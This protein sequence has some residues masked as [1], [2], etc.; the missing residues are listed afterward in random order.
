MAQR[1]GP[2]KTT[3]TTRGF[4][5]DSKLTLRSFLSPKNLDLSKAREFLPF[6]VPVTTTSVGR[7]SGYIAMSHVAS[8][9]LGTI[10]MAGHQI[11]LSIF[12]C[13]TPFVDALSQVA[14]SLV[15]EVFAA[16]GEGKRR[17]GRR[18]RAIA[19][20]RTIHNFRKVGVG[21][22]A[23]LVGL[24]SVIPLISRYFTT[25]ASV[26]ASVHGAIKPL[27]MFMLV[28]GLMCAGEGEKVGGGTRFLLLIVRMRLRVES[29]NVTLLSVSPPIAPLPTYSNTAP[30]STYCL[31]DL[32][33]AHCWDRRI[34]SSY[35][36]CTSS[37]FS[38]FRLI[39]YD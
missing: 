25:D 36:T 35:G 5:S 21:L 38:P 34:S 7:I 17:S 11:I 1:R 14:Q 30:L 31:Y 9:T 4:L 15:P 12:C 22:G 8:S 10:D 2:R 24:V 33:K 13:I 19:L 39:C 6:V 26:L 16:N 37:S 28:N 32:L 20:R 3:T 29:T 27:G 23:V 18:E